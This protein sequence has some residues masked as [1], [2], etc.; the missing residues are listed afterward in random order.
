MWRT[1]GSTER[2]ENWNNW[3]AERQ[4]S[5]M[6]VTVLARRDAYQTSF[7]YNQNFKFLWGYIFLVDPNLFQEFSNYRAFGGY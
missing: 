4:G 2:P 6:Q 1:H 7:V 5:I 3:Y